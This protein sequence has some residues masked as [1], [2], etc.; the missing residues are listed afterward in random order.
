LGVTSILVKRRATK[1]LKEGSRE[2][3]SLEITSEARCKILR[4]KGLRRLLITSTGTSLCEASRGEVE[5]LNKWL[6]TGRKSLKRSTK[7][8]RIVQVQ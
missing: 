4:A 7:I 8:K 5:E 6:Q 2:R 3:G 1:W